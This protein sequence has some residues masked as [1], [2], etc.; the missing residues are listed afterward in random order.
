[1]NSSISVNN[2]NNNITSSSSSILLF[3]DDDDID[4]DMDLLSTKSTTT[5]TTTDDDD[6]SLWSLSSTEIALRLIGAIICI[7][8]IIVTIVGN[9]LVII[10]VARFHRM[11]TVTNILLASHW[12][13]IK[14]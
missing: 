3:N 14:H 1:M 5:T 2:N 4:F 10:V 9:V 13:L 6:D 12:F 8:L 11:R 7:A